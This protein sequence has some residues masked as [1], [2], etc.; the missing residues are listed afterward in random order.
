MYICTII[1]LNEHIDSENP[2]TLFDIKYRK[3]S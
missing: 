3:T 2:F 1:Y